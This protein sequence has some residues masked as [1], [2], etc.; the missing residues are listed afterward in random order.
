MFKMT[1]HEEAAIK[2]ALR[3]LEQHMRYN[4][5]ELTSPELVKNYLKLR[6][7]GLEHE[8]FHIIF[9]DAQNKVISTDK[10]FIGT[11]TQTSIYPR[12][13]LK[14]ALEHNADAIILAHNHPSGFAQPS[15]ADEMMTQTLKS[16]LDLISVRVL[17]H[18]I[19]AGAESYSFAE[20]G[21]I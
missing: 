12:E 13:V 9:L 10:M 4:A 7:A 6:F 18:V 3:I 1:E 15:R 2:G 8:E 14:R 19:V 17:D 5:V 16:A 21:L 11:L 20:H